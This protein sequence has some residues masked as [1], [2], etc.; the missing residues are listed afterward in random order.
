MNG[1]TS[2]R[3]ESLRHICEQ[4]KLFVP[5]RPGRVVVT[6]GGSPRLRFVFHGVTHF[7]R[8]RCSAA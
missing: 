7:W 4:A 8:K 3:S 1:T 6:S 5:V 2:S